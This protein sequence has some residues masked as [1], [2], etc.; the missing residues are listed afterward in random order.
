MYL[1]QK[2]LVSNRVHECGNEIIKR[3]LAFFIRAC[4]TAA[5]K[6]IDQ[7][8]LSRQNARYICGTI[9]LLRTG[10]S[11]QKKPVEFPFIASVKMLGCSWAAL[12]VYIYV[13][14]GRFIH[15]APPSPALPHAWRYAKE[16]PLHFSSCSNRWEL[17]S[18]LLFPLYLS[19]APHYHTTPQPLCGLRELSLW[20]FAR[21]AKKRENVLKNYKIA[22]TSSSD[23]VNQDHS[24]ISSGASGR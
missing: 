6:R 19:C 14:G 8:Q 1:S 4:L 13:C 24:N 18:L 2:A 21:C 9:T 20:L 16:F 3:T 12:Y 22:E 5:A 7:E 15:Y 17:Y 23:P 10:C 11:S